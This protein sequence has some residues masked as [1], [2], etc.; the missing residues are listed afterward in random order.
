[1]PVSFLRKNRK[2]VD[3]MGGMVGEIGS[4]RAKE[5]LI[6]IYCMKKIISKKPMLLLLGPWCKS[7]MVAC[8]RQWQ[9]D[10]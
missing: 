2:G 4:S 10:L 6:R 3:R 8:W 5:T 1:M 7:L 9:A